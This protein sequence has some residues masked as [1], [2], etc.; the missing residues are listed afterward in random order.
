MVKKTLQDLVFMVDVIEHLN[1]MNKMLGGRNN[2]VTQCCDRICAFKL[3]LWETQL[4]RGDA[5]HFPCLKDG[6]A[7]Q[8]AADVKRFKDRLTGLLR[9]FE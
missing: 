2:V 1:N 6:C 7:T 4:T 3:S 9:G 8:H 5:A